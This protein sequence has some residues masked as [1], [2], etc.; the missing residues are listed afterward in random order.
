MRQCC[1]KDQEGSEKW[2]WGGK[3]VKQG[4]NSQQNP[5]SWWIQPCSGT[6]EFVSA[7]RDKRGLY[8]LPIS[9]L[10][11]RC[12]WAV[13]CPYPRQ[14]RLQ[15]SRWKLGCWW[16]GR[17]AQWVPCVRMEKG[18]EAGRAR[19]SRHEDAAWKWGPS[20]LHTESGPRSWGEGWSWGLT[21]P[22][23]YL[24]GVRARVVLFSWGLSQ[25]VLSYG[26]LLLSGQDHKNFKVRKH[27]EG[28]LANPSLYTW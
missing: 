4:R 6:L 15:Q 11:M 24:L 14:S 21:L 25:I 19:G 8:L 27:I 16:F 9:M 20:V 17:K 26:G 13:H 22:G 12:P 3:E 23:S 7:L 10:P 1:V 28:Y 2:G 18:R 5:R